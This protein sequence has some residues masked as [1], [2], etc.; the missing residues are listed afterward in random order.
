MN[1]VKDILNTM[2]P[3]AGARLLLGVLFGLS[4]LVFAAVKHR[5]RR[6]EREDM[7]GP[8]T[9]DLL[10]FIVL[11]GISAYGFASF[12]AEQFFGV[13][14]DAVQ[15]PGLAALGVAVGAVFAVSGLRWCARAPQ[16]RALYRQMLGLDKEQCERRGVVLTSLSAERTGTVRLEPLDG[17]EEPEDVPAR[18]AQD[19]YA[20]CETLL[21]GT[22][23]CV[24]SLKDDLLI[25]KP[26]G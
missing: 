2:S 4:F 21:P 10:F 9:A 25:V 1:A 13:P 18:A 8:F 20:R 26:R 14:S 5:S 16:R 6:G 24:V 19:L 22:E 15:T 17:D 7:A 3:F 12:A 11:A 23:V